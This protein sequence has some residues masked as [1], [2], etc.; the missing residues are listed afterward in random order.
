M[1]LS[2]LLS[3]WDDFFV[4][5]PSVS[6]ETCVIMSYCDR[7]TFEFC[8]N[9]FLRCSSFFFLGSASF[10]LI[11]RV[12]ISYGKSNEQRLKMKCFFFRRKS[13]CFYSCINDVRK[14]SFTVYY[15]QYSHKILKNYCVFPHSLLLF[16]PFRWRE[17]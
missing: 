13:N 9:L 2:V 14:Q 17:T 7:R 4:N 1:L 5:Q 8:P 3:S 10:R 16:T 15:R 12:A 11:L 6:P